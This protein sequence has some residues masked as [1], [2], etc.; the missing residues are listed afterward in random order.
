MVRR[1]AAWHNGG[2][3]VVAICGANTEEKAF[4][5]KAL[6][7]KPLFYD[8]KIKP[9][10]IDPHAQILSVFIDTP[11]TAELIASLPHLKLIVTRSTGTSHIDEAAAKAR[12]ITIANVPTYGSVTV[13]EYTFTLLLMLTRNM[14][15]VLNES[16]VAKPDRL[17]E[18]GTDLFGK[19]IGI[20]G[21]GS[22]GLGAAK[23][24][25][26]FGMNVI[27]Y[28]VS[29]R[30]DQAAKIGFTYKKNVD[31][32]IAASDII[33]LHIPFTPQNQH[34]LDRSRLAKLKHGAII[35]NT[36]RGELIDTVALVDA[37][38]NGHIYAAALDVLE[39]EYLLD[40]DQLID[41]AAH[42][43]AAKATLRHAVS[44]AALQ[45]MPNVIITNHNAYNT[46]EALERINLTA[47][48][49]INAYLGGKKD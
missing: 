12:G 9:G 22:I 45:H 14:P 26:G 28:D 10:D 18:R 20:I 8:A 24:A 48:K 34:F 21:T 30:P 31:E 39:S 44:L 5:T 2:M 15:Q 36:A 47:A 11:V 42:D 33:T 35:I 25:I 27:G 43:T 46:K 3:Q 41:L 29:P 37:L 13:A 4:F 49:S 17:R 40:P 7:T 6:N 1:L 38:K 32:L 23:I 19:T 16:V